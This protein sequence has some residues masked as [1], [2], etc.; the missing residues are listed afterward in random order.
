MVHRDRLRTVLALAFFVVA[1]II[2]AVVNGPINVEQL[3]WSVQNPPSDWAR[4]RDQWQLAHAARTVALGAAL[5]CI[6]VN[7]RSRERRSRP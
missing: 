1:M 3:S 7:P 6:S 2:T 5:V 4:V